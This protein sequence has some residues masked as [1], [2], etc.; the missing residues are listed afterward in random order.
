MIN[1]HSRLRF[2]RR[3]RTR[4]KQVSE[5]SETAN[6]QLDR[7]IFRRW[8]NLRSA[9]RFMTAWLVLV[10]I[11]IAGVVIQTRAL[12]RYYL[13]PKAVSGGVYTEGVVGSFTNANPIYAS[14]SVD[15]AVSRLV[16]AGL[17]TYNEQNQLVGDLAASWQANAN[18]TE[19]IV[20]LR[21]NLV[22]HDGK[23]LTADDVIFTFHTIQ[24]PD[25]KSPL[26]VNWTGVKI[27]KVSNTS[28][29]FTLPAGFS[30]FPHSLT[31][32]ILPQHLLKDIPV[33]ELRS[34]AFNTKEP[35]GAGPFKWS[36]VTIVGG[37]KVGNN[38]QRIQLSRFDDFRGS[39]AKLDGL[40][41]YTYP[42]AK[43]L[44]AALDNRKVI[45]AVGL[46]FNQAQEES[47]QS[48]LN[49]PLST[50]TMI[51]LKNTNPKLADVKVRQALTQATN[52]PEITKKL[53][54]PVIP[55]DQ[56]LLKMHTGYS[57]TNAQFDF[58]KAEAE[59]LLNEAGWVL[60][61]GE[62]VRKKGGEELSLNLISESN[63]E[64][65][66][67]ISELQKQWEE[68]GVRLDVSL[69]PSDTIAQSFI[70]AHNYDVLLY[71]ITIGPDPDVFAYWH[72]SQADVKSV[73]RLNLSEYKS[74]T[75]NI[76]LES[77]RTR[78]DPVVRAARYKSF[79][80]TWKKDAPAIGLYQPVIFYLS[81]QQVFGMNEKTI[82]SA[83]DRYNN[84]QNWMINTE[85]SLKD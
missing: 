40:S 47:G 33:A 53:G 70:L 18:S 67:L 50:S 63:G 71:G 19:F 5:I 55:V 6:K 44:R 13:E 51:F 20:R 61:P 26:Q 77:A 38:Q 83:A 16:F 84:A 17:L 4:K 14:N 73:G 22:W 45:G 64:Y 82:N 54:Y 27:D 15:S 30:P 66:K 78:T 62:Q 8:H 32:G 39:P 9:R 36:T 49:Y 68:I 60:A 56:P 42:E 72:S 3:L 34:A 23:P 11:L 74:S 1:R 35:V 10:A 41:I 2:R 85:R 79:A 80:E 76:A 29:K 48:S 28:V 21:P 31:T 58:N 75:A 81:N 37:A 12:G 65:T 25:A 52:V 46:P 57:A 7:H 43:D 59:R 24:N 69:Q